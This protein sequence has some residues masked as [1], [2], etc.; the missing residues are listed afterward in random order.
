ML[1]AEITNKNNDF[2]PSAYIGIGII[3]KERKTKMA[4]NKGKDPLNSTF[5]EKVMY[6][7]GDAGGAMILTFPGSY[8]TLYYTDSVGMAVAFVGT[9]LLVCRL[10]DGLS[11]ILMGV[12]I[13][14]TH[15]KW[16]KARPWFALSVIPLALS[17][18]A[19]FMMP[20]NLTIVGQRAYAYVTYFLL[21]VVF[22]TI[23]NVSYHAMLQRFSLTA[24]D[25]GTVSAVRSFLCVV[26]AAGL[27]IATPILIPKFGGE[28]SQTTWTTLVLIFGGIST[29]CLLITACGIKEKL[30]AIAKAPDTEEAKQASKD[31]TRTAVKTLLRCPYFYI[32]GAIS[33]VWFT[34]FNM[35]GINYY[36]A[37]D[38]L[39]D[40][41]LASIL[42]IVSM[43]P[44]LVAMPFVPMLFNKLG[45]RKTVVAGLSIGAIAS[46]C[47]LINPHSI[48][49]NAV[50]LVIKC[51]GGAPLMAAVATLAGDVTDYNQMRTGIRSEGAT[52]S[53]YSVGVKLGTGLGGAIVAWALAIGR[54]DATLA[55]QPASATSAMIVTLCVIPAILY[56]I[57]AILMF[58]WDLEKYQPEIEA[59]MKKQETVTTE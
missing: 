31:E 14:R 19:L 10:L 16:G 44:M 51:I 58:R 56:A 59:F 42:S 36:Y 23:N 11:D 37:R 30:P 15:T 9:M 40:G 47:I 39:G 22:Y 27:S 13:D 28:A 53:V 6:G 7:V 1:W 41:E 29:L 57:G 5:L 33:L 54:Y 32:A 20:K 8:L 3:L 2:C 12:L 38:V 17:F 21:T 48:A 43:M 18:I 45:K 52:T 46:L 26:F 24:K 35:T 55:V 4:K 50:C 25:R 49:V 34:S